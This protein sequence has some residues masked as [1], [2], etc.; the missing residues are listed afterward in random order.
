MI[1]YNVY[2]KSIEVSFKDR[3]II[4]PGVVHTE[5]DGEPEEI[6]GF[7]TLDKAREF[8]KGFKTTI[9]YMSN[10]YFVEEYYIEEN[11]YNDDDVDYEYPSGGEVWGY[12]KM[13]ID[14][15][16][17]ISYD[18]LG[19]FDNMQDALNFDKSL[20]NNDPTFLSF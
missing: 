13:K 19:T 14:V 1:R 8:L 4:R 17:S 11:E 20:D 9:Q 5:F 3:Q 2:K 12:S 6:K 15:V 10:V 7:D 16:S 18:V